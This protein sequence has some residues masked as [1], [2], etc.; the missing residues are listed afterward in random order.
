MFAIAVLARAVAPTT[1][2]I[3]LDNP[4]D[5]VGHRDTE[6]DDRREEGR[7]ISP[8]NSVVFLHRHSRVTLRR[9]CRCGDNA[10]DVVIQWAVT[11]PISLVG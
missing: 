8:S 6:L 10:R 5:R 3:R 4:I 7:H 11:L 9:R 2:P 1:V